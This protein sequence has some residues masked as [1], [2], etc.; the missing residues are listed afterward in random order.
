ML[1]W[2]LKKKTQGDEVKVMGTGVGHSKNLVFTLHLAGLQLMV[3]V[4]LK[5]ECCTSAKFHMTKQP[6]LGRH[7]LPQSEEGVIKGTLKKVCPYNFPGQYA[8][9]DGSLIFCGS[10]D[11]DNCKTFSHLKFNCQVNLCDINLQ[12]NNVQDLQLACGNGN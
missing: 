4:L 12:K 5:G 11:S 7:C 8:S 1:Y 10:K 9:T 2:A 3:V 6:N